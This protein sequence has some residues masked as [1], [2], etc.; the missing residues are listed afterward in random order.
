VAN[1]DRAD[2]YVDGRP[3]AS[4]DTPTSEASV[5]VPGVG[6]ATVVRAEGFADGKL[7]AARTVAL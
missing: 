2:V 7:V 4:V 6:Q 5:T 1:V 3:R